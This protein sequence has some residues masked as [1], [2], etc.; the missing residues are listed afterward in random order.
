[1]ARVL[2]FGGT[3]VSTAARIRE[4]AEISKSILAEE[5]KVVVIVSAMG[6]DP[7]TKYIGTTDFLINMGKKAVN[8]D[9]A[10]LEDLAYLE[11]R[12]RNAAKELLNDENF[13]NFSNFLDAKIKN[14]SNLLNGVYLL[15]EM[16]PKALD[17]ICSFGELCSSKLVAYYFSEKMKDV[18]FLDARRV[19]RT[20]SDFGAAIVNFNI[21]NEQILLQTKDE[22]MY[23]MGGFIATNDKEMTTTLGRGGSDY[24]AAIMAAGIKADQL[25]IWTDVN[26]VMTADPRKVKDAFSLTHLT[27]EEAMEMSH[28]GAKVLHPPTVQPAFTNNIPIYIKNTFNPDYPG[29][30]ISREVNDKH[31]VKGVS[32]IG[33]VS[34][35]NIQ[36]TGL[37]GVSGIAAR[38]FNALARAKVNIILITQASSEHSITFAVKPEDT[39]RAS[40]VI[41]NEFEYEIN[42]NQIN[43][44]S[45]QSDLAIVAIIGS[46]M[47][48]VSGIS[49]RLFKSLGQNGINVYAIAQGSSELNISAVI[50]KDD[51]NKA[52][53]ALH[54]SFFLSDTKTLNLFVLGVGLIGGT[55]L[56]QIEKQTSKLLKDKSLRFRIV[57][58]SNSRKMLFDENGIAIEAYKDRLEK[59]GETA[60]LEGF[61]DK[62]IG[63]NLANSIFIDCTASK[64]PSESY[65]KIIK[66][67][68]SIITPNKVANTLSQEKYENLRVLSKANNARFKYETNVGAGLPVI[69]TLRDLI[70]SGDE[71]HKITAVLSGSLSFIFNSFKIGSSFYEI[72]KE[73]KEK[74]YTEP[75]PRDDLGLTD[76]ARKALILS[77]EIGK[78]M[79]LSD[80]GIEPIM[81]EKCM[82]AE[83]VDDFFEELKSHN[84]YFD[85]L[86]QSALDK[87]QVLRI[88]AE[89]TKEKTSVKLMK[90]D[91]SNPFYS[92]TGSENMIAFQTER[93]FDTPLVVRGPGAG[94]EVT[95]AG[96]FAEIITE[97]DELDS[98]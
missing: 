53:N 9:K 60:N 80:I 74:G 66:E 78:K 40:F 29:T 96:V 75:D 42:A 34:L 1:M 56:K 31:L 55:L 7:A 92:L 12:H 86:L 41:D 54:Q 22:G 91:A 62:M 50:H 81:P 2:K 88:M 25:E 48:K 45:V 98:N 13:I 76:V 4:I 87:Q 52:L 89:I 27:Y 11:E 73:A 93:Y 37:I 33:N 79:E 63:C 32:S 21:T 23:V 51:I 17:C 57:A 72:V 5:D 83:T 77:R 71:V 26:G 10:F 69:S 43:P 61:V 6:K 84:G 90:V 46:G 20:N 18:R 3:S 59:E 82:D 16:S 35:L 95:A 68:I 94:A 30:C 70:N 38:L 28:F 47:R 39:E 15:K 19:V 65:E 44:V 58:L 14:L 49:G 24:S 8:A 97:A 36:G 85:N 64:A 67:S